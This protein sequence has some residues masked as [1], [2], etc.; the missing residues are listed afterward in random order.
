VLEVGC[1]FAVDASSLASRTGAGG[2]GVDLSHDALRVAQRAC[3]PLGHVPGLVVADGGRMPFRDG[4]F[5]LVFSQGFL[6]HFE[7]P[8]PMLREQQRVTRSGGHVVVNVPQKYNPYTLYKRRR[9]REGTW[10]F[11]WETEFSLGDL[12]RLGRRLGLRAVS[13]MGHGYERG[14]DYGF[15]HVREFTRRMARTKRYPWMNGS[16]RCGERIWEVLERRLG[17]RFCL[18]VA[19]AFEV[20]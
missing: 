6:E 2:F 12:R 19:V 8:L 7:D 15:F 13:W 1:G 9:I 16:G 17:H 4:S 14:R 3:A 20:G 18:N 5:D 11:G 10:E